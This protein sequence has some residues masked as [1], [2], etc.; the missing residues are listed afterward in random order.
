MGII[1]TPFGYIMRFCA[2]L[3]FNNYALALLLFTLIV[4]VVLL[5]FG[6][7]QQSTQIK[8]AKLRPKI[9]AIE[10]KYAGRTDR[11]TLQKKQQE[12]MELQQR[13]GVSMFGGC[14]PL[15]IQLPI[16]FGLYSVIREPLTYLMRYSDETIRAIQERLSVTTPDQIELISAIRANPDAV[17][18]LV[19]VSDLPNFSL[20]GGRFDLSASPSDTFPSLLILIPIIAA[21]LSYLTV[22]ITRRLSGMAMATASGD[23]QKSN[24]IMDLIMPLMSG[25]LSW[26]YT[27]LLG[28]YWIYQSL[29][30]IVQSFLLAKL[31]PLP[32]FSAEDLKRAEKEMKVEEAKRKPVKIRSLHHIDDDDEED[33]AAQLSSGSSSRYGD[34]EDEPSAP[35]VIQKATL[36]DESNKPQPKKKNKKKNEKVAPTETE[37]PQADSDNAQTNDASAE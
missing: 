27:A 22:R 23:A 29:F 4:K 5:P 24:M 2:R 32:K 37:A 26:I 30:G 13:E 3:C 31:M 18:G 16:L 11:P 6:I 25:Y 35:T 28:V 1:A 12:I 19:N 15:L 9:A 20:F 10:K 33:M 36:K 21:V 14:L 8:A 17:S 7:K 34:D